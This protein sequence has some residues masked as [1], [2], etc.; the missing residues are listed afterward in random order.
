[1]N[2]TPAYTEGYTVKLRSGHLQPESYAAESNY[3]SQEEKEAQKAR[4]HS[5]NTVSNI[6]GF[7]GRYRH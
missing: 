1:M 5:S 2:V 7:A 6:G 4:P 3:T